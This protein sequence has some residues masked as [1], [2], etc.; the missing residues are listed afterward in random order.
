MSL[1]DIMSSAGLT[2]WPIAG[3]VLF[4][5]AFVLVAFRTFGRGSKQAQQEAASLPL[6]DAPVIN[7]RNTNALGGES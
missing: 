4:M 3:L 6:Q 5:F 1:T 7:T 2:F